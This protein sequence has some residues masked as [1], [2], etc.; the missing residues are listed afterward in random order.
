M[1]DIPILTMRCNNEWINNMNKLFENWRKHLNENNQAAAA[2]NQA[3]EKAQGNAFAMGSMEPDINELIASVAELIK[4]TS[5]E[6]GQRLQVIDAAINQL[7]GTFD[8]APAMEQFLVRLAGVKNQ[9]S[10]QQQ[11]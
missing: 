3:I 5:R 1:T 7:S 6:G 9:L 8:D 2:V 4:G 10:Q 11:V